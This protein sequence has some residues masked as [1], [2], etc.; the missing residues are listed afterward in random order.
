V[1]PSTFNDGSGHYHAWL[2]ATDGTH[3]FALHGED[4]HA[5]PA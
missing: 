3:V 4:L 5:L 2:V 1:T